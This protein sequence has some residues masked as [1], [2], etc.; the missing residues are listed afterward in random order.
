[1]SDS[2]SHHQSARD[3]R[4][5]RRSRRRL[6]AAL[7][8]T[9]GSASLGCALLTPGA[10]PAAP[11][12]AARPS[13]S[14]APRIAAWEERARSEGSVQVYAELTLAEIEALQ[15]VIGS[16]HPG[17]SVEWTYGPDAELLDLALKHTD[18]GRP[19]WDVYVGDAGTRLARAGL[20]ARWTPPEAGALRHEYADPGGGWHAMAATYYVLQ[21]HTELVPPSARPARYEDLGDS[22]FAHRLAAEQ[23]PLTWLAGLVERLGRTETGQLLES[24]ATQGVTP[25]R[26]AESLSQ[27]VASGRYALA[28]ANRL[29]AVERD[30]QSGAKTAWV[31]LDPLIAQPTVVVVAAEAAHASGAR[32]VAN[33]LLSAS[34]QAT[35]AALGRVPTR[36]D[37][38]AE[39]AAPVRRL[40]PH[41]TL[42]PDAPT[43][44]ELRDL[45]A[46]LWS[47]K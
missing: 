47:R 43:E 9:A 17:V 1:M 46:L 7:V 8:V 2:P 16:A 27:A 24:L 42:S 12:P 14:P 38:D 35:L 21:Y 36:H 37:L 5:G 18:D 45:Y 19:G 32:L 29:E 28:I 34:A 6:I 22:R 26:G 15:A 41:V 39:V 20:T 25:R 44:Q 23:E 33:A 30:R 4:A 3:A 31:A 10:D 11:S 40:R 13:P